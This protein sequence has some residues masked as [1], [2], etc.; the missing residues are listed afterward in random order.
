MGRNV[1]RGGK[2]SIF[3]IFLEEQVCGYKFW[4]NKIYYGLDFK[5]RGRSVRGEVEE[6]SKGQIKKGFNIYGEQC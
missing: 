6:V 3:K 5:Y 1:K 2:S 4:G